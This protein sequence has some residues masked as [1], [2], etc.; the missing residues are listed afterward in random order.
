[1]AT[2]KSFNRHYLSLP[3]QI[4]VKQN[5]SVQSFREETEIRLKMNGKVIQESGIS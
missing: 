1:M 2:D 3:F 4:K 5:E